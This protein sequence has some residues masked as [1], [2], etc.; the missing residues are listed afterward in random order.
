MCPCTCSRGQPTDAHDRI[1]VHPPK[2]LLD[3]QSGGIL[4]RAEREIY[5][6]RMAE[7]DT[8]LFDEV[9]G[10]RICGNAADEVRRLSTGNMQMSLLSPA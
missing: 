6:I 7:N 10:I 9:S 1:H 3:A 5:V 2:L 8:S 4:T